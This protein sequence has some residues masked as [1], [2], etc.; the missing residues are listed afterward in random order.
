MRRAVEAKFHQHAD[1][2]QILLATGDAVLVEHA[3]NDRY[4]ANGG[5]G[6]G[7]NMLGIIL[8][9]VRAKLRQEAA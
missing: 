2:L 4:W 9:E 7:K 1:I 3:S 6:S 8:M 5:D